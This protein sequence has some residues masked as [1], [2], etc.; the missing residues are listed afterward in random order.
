MDPEFIEQIPIQIDPVTLLL[1]SI[2]H[3]RYCVTKRCI[4]N[5]KIHIILK[6]S[7]NLREFCIY[8]IWIQYGDGRSYYTVYTPL[9]SA[10]GPNGFGTNG[11]IFEWIKYVLAWLRFIN[12][13]IVEYLLYS[14]KFEYRSYSE[15]WNFYCQCMKQTYQL[16]G[17]W[18]WLGDMVGPS[19]P[20]WMLRSQ[21]LG[22]P[23]SLASYCYPER[24]NRWDAC[25]LK[26]HLRFERQR[27]EIPAYIVLMAQALFTKIQNEA[28][29]N[30]RQ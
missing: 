14:N 7:I 11:A 15:R 28:D 5:S 3:Q 18:T 10:V 20:E 30:L 27:R 19:A 17:R 21:P 22:V 4:I 13:Y 23:F 9:F 2:H 25:A 12:V 24:I 26:S 29:I 6:E 16:L 8:E 1:R